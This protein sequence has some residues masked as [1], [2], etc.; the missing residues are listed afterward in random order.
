M[1]SALGI[2]TT[3][4]VLPVAR[5]GLKSHD[6]VSFVVNDGFSSAIS[7]FSEISFSASE[8]REMLDADDLIE[9]EGELLSMG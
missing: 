3:G 5:K 7:D 9:D 2:F 6:D 4:G 8:L 1:T